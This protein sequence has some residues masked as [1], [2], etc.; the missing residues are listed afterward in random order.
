MSV[1]YFSS[2]LFD[3]F[4]FSGIVIVAANKQS[5][6]VGEGRGGSFFVSPNNQTSE[7]ECVYKQMK[8]NCVFLNYFFMLYSS[9]FIL[10]CFYID[11]P[12]NLKPQERKR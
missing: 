1:A 12:G 9:G 5:S 11:K 7:F 10:F 4:G 8:W 3:D 6:V 2:G